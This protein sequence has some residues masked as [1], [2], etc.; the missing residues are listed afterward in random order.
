MSNA[1][2]NRRSAGWTQTDYERPAVRRAACRRPES[3]VVRY[4]DNHVRVSQAEHHTVEEDVS[5][6][7]ALAGVLVTAGVLLGFWTVANAVTATDIGSLSGATE[8]VRVSAGETLTDVAVRIAP[9]LPA[10][11]VVERIMDLNAMSTSSLDSG[12]SLL[13]PA[14]AH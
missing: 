13:V 3:G 1:V 9:E 11:Q 2:L 14:S 8:V 5:W 7:M 6:R 4:R 10:R 12:Q